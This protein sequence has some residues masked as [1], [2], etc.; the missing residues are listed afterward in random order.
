MTG[1]ILSQDDQN[2]LLSTEMGRTR[3]MNAKRLVIKK[4]AEKL[5]YLLLDD[6]H[7]ASF[8]RKKDAKDMQE[9]FFIKYFNN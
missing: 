9:Q 8:G 4:V 6:I 7:I 1:L 2:N 5:Y 3:K